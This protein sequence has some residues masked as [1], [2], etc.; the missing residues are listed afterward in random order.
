M[1]L[2][3]SWST[4]ALS[5]P[6][7]HAGPA[8][9]TLDE[10]DLIDENKAFDPRPQPLKTLKSSLSQRSLAILDSISNSDFTYQHIKPVKKVIGSP[11]HERQPNGALAPKHPDE[12]A[13]LSSSLST[14]PS[15]LDFST[16]SR[17]TTAWLSNLAD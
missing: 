13:L 11:I 15:L 1:Q 7:R 16:S 8:Q 17:F 3:R 10:F 9:E 12:V 5:G 2:T 6:R 4:P 14:S